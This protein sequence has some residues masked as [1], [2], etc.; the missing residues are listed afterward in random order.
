MMNQQK[1]SPEKVAEK[2]RLSAVLPS[3]GIRL[4]II[5][6]LTLLA[7]VGVIIGGNQLTL[8]LHQK[9]QRPITGNLATEINTFIV[10]HHIESVGELARATEV[11]SVCAGHAEVDNHDLLRVLNTAR[12]VMGLA[13]VYVMDQDGTVIGSSNAPEEPGLTGNNYSFRPYFIHA[14]AG[15]PYFFAGVGVTTGRKGF[16]FSAPVYAAPMENPVG[17]VVIKTRSETIDAFFSEL[18][19][20]LDALLLSPDG[21]VFASTRDEWNFRS[22]WPLSPE[23]LG[24]IRVSRQFSDHTLP[25][26]PFSLQEPTVRTDSIRATVDLQ[27]VDLPGWQ[28]ATLEKVPY[29]WVV[30]LALS[31]GVLSLGFLSGVVVLHWFREKQ[32]TGQML[33]NQEA[34]DR[35]EAAHQ[36]SVMELATIFKTS[37]VGIVLIRDGR[38]INANDRMAEMFGYLQEEVLGLDVRRFFT[39]Q[40]AFRR[41]VQSHLP[42][43]IEKDVKQVEY[44]LQK[45]D[46][47]VIPC[48]LSGKAIST[49]NLALGTVW[50]VEDISERKASEQE[51]VQARAEAE[52][53]SVAKGEFLANMSHEIR[54]PMNGIIGLSNI[55]LREEMPPAQRE[56]LEL[57]QRSAIRLMTIIN[58]ILDFSKLEAGRF[59]LA[60]QPFSLRSA[61]K[62][63]IRP[64]EP[65]AERKHLQIKVTVDPAVPDMLI[66]DQ[67]KLMQV[68]T[69]LID[70]SLKFTRKGY[71][72]IRVDCRQTNGPEGG[73]LLFEIADTGIGIV[74]AYHAKVFES[75]SQADSSHSRKVGGTGLGLSISKGL[76]ELMGGEI[77]FDSEPDMGTRFY[78]TLPYV[79]PKSTAAHPGNHPTIHT[80]VKPV[81]VT[82]KKPRILVA[83]DEYINKILIRT[84]L[85]QAGYHVTVVKNGREAVEAWR[86][87]V[88]DC[89]LMDVQMPEMD[90]YEAVARI[91]EAEQEGEHIPVIAMTA[92]AMSDDRRKCLAAGMDE[93]VAKP[94]DGSAV[95]HLLRQFIPDPGKDEV[96]ES[97]RI[98]T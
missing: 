16:Y 27:P 31:S 38:V 71:V 70:N 10:R 80:N 26:L 74:Q 58:D 96:D 6:G 22:A 56:H 81:P 67:T 82:G 37:L 64:M 14:L 9:H 65:T 29:P 5:A 35:A 87:G 77:W 11:I 4:T 98:A 54:T 93:Y 15:R 25:P 17:V 41:F 47:T 88:F 51:L 39:S 3:V 69:N 73:T 1:N 53:A 36:T 34:S 40:R 19:A 12:G 94:I 48:T 60:R 72:A 7:L 97:V 20:Q 79:T 42:L 83:E 86:G 50:V 49:S 89:I 46:G 45:K 68:L 8:L 85:T 23:R 57:I 24:E 18:T 2:Y 76:V 33:A 43:L 66:G 91:R 59:E 90:G 32:L 28:I 55:L 92:H 52:A 75:F 63:V 84:L 13:L 44:R 62:E 95:L 30:V 21:I 61:L 78:F